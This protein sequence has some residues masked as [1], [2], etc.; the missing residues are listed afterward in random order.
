[1]AASPG[2]KNS[3]SLAFNTSIF[4]MASMPF[5]L[6]GVFGLTFWRWS[7][8][9]TGEPSGGRNECPPSYKS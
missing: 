1:L 3:S 5:L 8:Q 6:T 9:G 4:V 2:S 7:R